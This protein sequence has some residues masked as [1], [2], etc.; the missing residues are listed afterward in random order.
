MLKLSHPNTLLNCA[1]ERSTFCFKFSASCWQHLYAKVRFAGWGKEQRWPIFTCAALSL[2]LAA[3]SCGCATVGP[4][5]QTGRAEPVLPAAWHLRD[6]M[7]FPAWGR[8]SPHRQSLGR[9][10]AAERAPASFLQKAL[11][12]GLCPHLAKYLRT[13]KTRMSIEI[14]VG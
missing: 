8:L 2:A 11:K 9:P 6:S 5:V 14:T 10:W 4:C 1:W 12:P 3:A 7:F 13:N